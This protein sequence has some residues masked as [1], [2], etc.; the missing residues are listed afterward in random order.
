MLIESKKMVRIEYKP[1]HP[2]MEGYDKWVPWK[3]Y[4]DLDF[5]NKRLVELR[6][7]MPDDE[8]RCVPV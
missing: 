7:L 3:E 1:K 4:T 6:T 2:S 5:V 8:W